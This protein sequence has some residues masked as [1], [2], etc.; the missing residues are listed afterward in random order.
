M[1]TIGAGFSMS[2]DGFIA[3]PNDDVTH[4]FAWMFMGETDV[5]AEIGDHELDLK[6]TQE[7]VEEREVMVNTLGAIIS[8]RRLFDM[9]HGWGGKH[10]ANVP[11]VLLTHRE[12]PDWIQPEW[13]FEVAHTLEDAI[14]KAKQLAGGKSIGVAGADVAQ[15]CLKAGVMDEIGIDLVPVLLGEGI[16]F[17]KHLGIEPIHFEITGVTPTPH[18]THLRYR[19][20]R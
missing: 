3:G 18:V 12:S 5:K 4:V 8:G 20:K 15:Q 2:L 9:T 10:P 17:F 13:G 1:S 19:V 7:S 16:P 11:I 6:L 14:A